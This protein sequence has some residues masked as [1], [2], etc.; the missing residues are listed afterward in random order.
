MLSEKLRP[1][2]KHYV[3]VLIPNPQEKRQNA[4]QQDSGDLRAVPKRGV[5]T[6]AS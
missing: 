4:S 3:V 1:D 2:V 5:E 6:L